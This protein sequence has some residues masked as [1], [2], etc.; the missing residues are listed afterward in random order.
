MYQ[1][2][3]RTARASSNSKCVD[4]ERPAQFGQGKIIDGRIQLRNA[5]H[6]SITRSLKES[7]RDND[8]DVFETIGTEKD[9]T[10]FEPFSWLG[11]LDTSEPMSFD[12]EEKTEFDPLRDGPLR[13]LGYSNELGEAFSAWLFPGGVPLSYAV[14]VSYVLFDTWDKYTRTLV[15][16]EEKID[17]SACAKSVNKAKLVSIIGFERGIDTLVWQLLASVIIPGYTIHTIVGLSSDTLE[18]TLNVNPEVLNTAWIASTL[19]LSPEIV[20]HFA[21]KS[22]PTFLGLLTIPFIVHPIDSAVHGVLNVTLRPL[23]REYICNQGGGVDAGLAICND[24][25]K[26]T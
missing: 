10:R 5:Q 6:Y 2:G 4:T 16:A 26:E 1:T 12:G 9:K 17:I 15:D 23:L 21:E 13:Y 8:I 22:L 24:C 7:S 18:H 11:L 3:G 19:S 20:R 14:A 25:N